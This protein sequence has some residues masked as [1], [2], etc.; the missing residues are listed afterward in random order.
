M[1]GCLAAAGLAREV[2]HHGGHVD[3]LAELGLARAE[4]ALEPPEERLAGGPGEGTAEPRL[5]R[6]G[7]LA[8]QED[9]AH[10]RRAVHR[11]SDEARHPQ[12]A[13]VPVDGPERRDLPPRQASRHGSSRTE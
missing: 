1:S 11:R 5:V 10:D 2:P 6:P 9:A 4:G 8:E 3:P 12:R 7:R 13:D